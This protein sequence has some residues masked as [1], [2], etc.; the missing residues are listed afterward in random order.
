VK[1]YVPLCLSSKLQVPR[2]ITS[3]N[4]RVN[5]L[6]LK[7][8][9]PLYIRSETLLVPVRNFK[10][11]ETVRSTLSLNKLHVPL[12]HLIRC[13][14]QNTENMLNIYV[15]LYTLYFTPFRQ[16]I[17]EFSD[18]EKRLSYKISNKYCRNFL[19]LC[20]KI[21]E[22]FGTNVFPLLDDS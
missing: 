22:K 17:Q 16:F 20:T 2:D 21:I 8:Q 3:E 10:V 18:W 4:I 9:V 14:N 13:R 5:F 1:Q 15:L 7:L 6:R 11:S 12:G 19:V